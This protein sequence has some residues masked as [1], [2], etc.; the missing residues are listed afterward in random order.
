M[1]RYFAI[2][3]GGFLRRTAIINPLKEEDGLCTNKTLLHSIIDL[4]HR[5][6]FN[7]ILVQIDWLYAK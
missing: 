2:M 7:D 3:S 1:F 6:A 5:V 4:R